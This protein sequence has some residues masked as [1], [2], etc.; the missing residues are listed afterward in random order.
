MISKLVLGYTP[1]SPSIAEVGGGAVLLTH[2]ESNATHTA[3]YL[4]RYANLR[5]FTVA[6]GKEA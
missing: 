2:Q 4:S 1:W 3:E 6:T 5:A